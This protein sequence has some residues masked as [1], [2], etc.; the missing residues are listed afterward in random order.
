M[1]D[2]RVSPERCVR[3]GWCARDCPTGIIEQQGK[4]LPRI[5]P[6]NEEDCLQCQHCLAVCPKAAISILGRDPD[7]SI[8]LTARSFPKLAQM[9]RFVR[10]RRSVRHYRDENVAPAL[11]RELLATL[12]NVPTGVNRRRLTFTVIDD[13]AVMQRFRERSQA[14]LAAAHAAGRL[15]ERFAYLGSISERTRET[16][17]DIILRG[18]PHALVVS[19]APDAAC[20]YEDAVLALAYFELLAHSA[21]LGTVWCGLMKGALEVL[22]DL[23]AAIGLPADH[24]YYCMLFGY[25]AI[26]FARTVQ[27]DDAARVHRVDL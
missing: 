6:E 22:P 15:P 3:C 21:G 4:E 16:G 11:L 24:V 5:R 17:R 9:S 14:G 7:E 12:A 10:G 18:A 1:L 26:R 8:A 13:R 23:K 20:P 27:R 19:A 2:F 25:P